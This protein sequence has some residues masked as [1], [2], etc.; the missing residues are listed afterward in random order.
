MDWGRTLTFQIIIEFKVENWQNSGRNHKTWLD[1]YV[2]YN[3]RK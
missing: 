3:F 1:L 2:D